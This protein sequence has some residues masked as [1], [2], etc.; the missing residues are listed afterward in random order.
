[1]DTMYDLDHEAQKYDLPIDV[2]PPFEDT[3]AWPEADQFQQEFDEKASK[4]R[5]EFVRNGGRA[6]GKIGTN[7]QD[8]SIYIDNALE[9]VKNIDLLKIF[10][11]KSGYSRL[12]DLNQPTSIIANYTED[13]ATLH[14]LGSLSKHTVLSKDFDSI[15][16][17]NNATNKKEILHLLHENAEF[18]RNMKRVFALKFKFNK[19]DYFRGGQEEGYLDSRNIWKLPTNQGDDYFEINQQKMINKISASILIDISGS[20]D[21]TNTEHGKKLKVTALALSEAMTSVHINHE[22]LGYH[23]P[24]CDEMKLENA[25]Y[26]YNR[27]MNRLETVV[28]KTFMQRD[29]NGLSNF[30]LELSDNSD[31]ESVRIALQ[32]LKKERAKNKMLFI[33][34]DGKPFLSSAD[35]SI[36]DE[37]LKTALREAVQQKIQIFAIGFCPNG[38][39]FY[40]NRFCHALQYQDIINFCKQLPI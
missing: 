3:P 40:G 23:A 17:K 15:L 14:S 13:Q 29:N 27:R 10:G 2:L 7:L 38:E 22:I 35:I 6:A 16:I 25:S 26:T 19:K 11:E 24:I 32:R 37:D 31:G 12:P 34:T 36:L 1:M 28:Y 30:N 39:S 21:K 9:K 20:Q 33:L 18:I 5:K 8:L 4:I